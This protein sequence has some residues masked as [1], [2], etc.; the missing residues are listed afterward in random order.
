[1][2]KTLTFAKARASKWS[3]GSG[4]LEVLVAI[5]VLSVGML[6]MAKLH[7]TLIRE[8]STANN[9]AVAAKLAQSRLDQL[10]QFKYISEDV[11]RPAAE[12]CANANIVCFSEIQAD[13]AATDVPNFAGFT[14]QVSSVVDNGTSKNVQVTVN[15]NDPNGP[16]S[17]AL[18]STI[19]AINNSAQAIGDGSGVGAMSS[20]PSVL[21][22][23]GSTPEVVPIFVTGDKKREAERPE[24]D[25]NQSGINTIT[26]FSVANYDATT[27]RW[28]QNEEYATVNCTCTQAGEVTGQT[29]REPTFN[30][31][32][33]GNLVQKRTGIR[34]TGGQ[35]NQ[36]PAVCS[37]CCRDHHDANASTRKFD[38]FRPSA[39]FSVTGGDHKH[40]L[41][42]V[43][44]DNTGSDYDEACRLVR[45]NGLWYVTADWHL[46]ALVVAPKQYFESNLAAYQTRVANFVKDYINAIGDG[47]PQ[48]RPT[49]AFT[50]SPALTQ[51]F[52]ISSTTT[53]APF[54]LMARGIYIDHMTSTQIEAFKQAFGS[55]STPNLDN[56]PF[57]EVNLTRLATWNSVTPTIATVTNDALTDQS[58]NTY[59][60]G[61]VVK[62]STGGET[63]IRASIKRSNSGLTASRPIDPDDEAELTAQVTVST[64]GG[65]TLINKYFWG[66]F[67]F[68]NGTGVSASTVSAPTA[69][70]SMAC[71]VLTKNQIVPATGASCGS[72]GGCYSCVTGNT[73]W[74]GTVSMEV[75]TVNS[76]YNTATG[77]CVNPTPDNVTAGTTS[78]LPGN[79][80]QYKNTLHY[81]GNLTA[82]DVTTI[83]KDIAFVTCP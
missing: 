54:E 18:N 47:Y 41:N 71:T 49:T 4:L 82:A 73:S 75:V 16:G 79:K 35:Y 28:L 83:R 52:N 57:Q 38:P 9:R 21:H 80:T 1:M 11:T 34:K 33:I 14:W 60:R 67:T 13:A 44:A 48:T 7:T 68:G 81:N 26:N 24:P 27:N 25:I 46:A 5:L 78:S 2:N 56:V 8:G 74:T 53:A 37:L 22:T 36:Q 45:V 66:Q 64:S 30:A 3:R 20:G 58:E 50:L 42:L 62:G 63:T 65:T 55:G 6:S 51:P 17:V 72:N 31:A 39:D 29:G 10:R 77:Y 43:S 69:T 12:R 59:T 19:Y 70:N 15:W 23:P 40:F 32:N 61:R 76:Q